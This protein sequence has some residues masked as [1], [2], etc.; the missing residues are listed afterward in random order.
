MK[1]THFYHFYI[2]I[3]FLYVISQTLYAQVNVEWIKRF[4]Y[5]TD[6]WDTS[7]SVAVDGSGNIY[8]TG[9]SSVD[10]LLPF[11]Y[12]TIKYNASGEQQWSSRYDGFSEGD[13]IAVSVAIDGSGNVFVTGRSQGNSYDI[14]SIKYNSSGSQQWLERFNG[15]GNADD[16]AEA[17]VIDSYGNVYITGYSTGSYSGKDFI[18]IKYNSAG[19]QQWVSNY[20][21][22]GNGEDIAHSIKV[23]VYGNVYV[24]GRSKQNGASTDFAFA[25]VKYNSSGVQQWAAIYNGPAYDWDEKYSLVVDGDGNVFVTGKSKGLA[26]FFGNSLFDYLTLKYNSS[27]VQQWEARYNGPGND[28]D[29]AYSIVIDEENN[30]YITGR[31]IGNGANYDYAT[32]KYNSSGIQQWL[33]RYDNGNIDEAYSIAIDISGNVYVTGGSFEATGSNK[34]DYLTIKYSQS[35]NDKYSSPLSNYSQNSFSQEWVQRYNDTTG[36]YFEDSRDIAVDKQGNVYVT[37][38]RYNNNYDYLTVKYNS[39]GILQW[40]EIYEIGSWAYALT[41]DDFANVYVTGYGGIWGTGPDIITVKY[42]TSGIFQWVARY[43]GPLNAEDIGWEITTDNSGNIYVT[44]WSEG[45]GPTTDYITIKYNNSGIQQW[46]ARFNGISNSFDQARSVKVDNTGNVYVTG[47]SDGMITTIKYNSNGSQQW[48]SILN[49]T[50]IAYDIELDKNN[51]IYVCGYG[52]IQNNDF[53]TVKYNSSGNLHWERVY[54]GTANGDDVSRWMAIDTIGNIYV[55]GYSQGNGSGYDYTA[56]KYNSSG[57]QLWDSRYNGSGNGNDFVRDVALDRSGNVY[58]AGYSYVLS[59]GT[60]DFATVKLNAITGTQLW[61]ATYN[62]T[63]DSSDYGWALSVDSLNNVYVT[64]ASYGIE[65][66]LDFA[67]IKYSQIISVQQIS[68]QIPSKY[69]LS[70]NYPN[71]FNSLTK[72]KFSIPEISFIKLIV[73]DILG[74]VIDVLVNDKI[75]SG[76]YE[77]SWDAGNYSS[78]I[79]FYSIDSPKFRDTKKMIVIK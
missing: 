74:R 61:V 57:V 4:S 14:V 51:N 66:G 9:K 7:Y 64:G 15:T 56:V 69:N 75:N 50:S 62:G 76:I 11:D 17:M 54:N 32:I 41:L 35:V 46:A 70:Q 49:R 24:T 25:T 78:G 79:Y 60:F 55:A 6:A 30:I 71:P 10:P 2:F 67:T 19:V 42:N 27:G 22:N 59:A 73:Y 23:D 72:I 36:F 1:K 53:I 63:G 31:S 68:E 47:V 33:E 21:G 40:A 16:A 34:L 37:G 5:T 8:V 13:D 44:G 20:N 18:T 3:F 65:T 45:L 12:A 38:F 77:V 39:A 58:I 52:G 48:I 43:N 26:N 28:N 29:E